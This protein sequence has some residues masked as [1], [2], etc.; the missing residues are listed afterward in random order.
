MAKT[1]L[2]IALLLA[3]AKAGGLLSRRLKMPEVL[4]ALL[5]GVI[6]GPAGFHL[7]RYDA[8]IQLLS[9]LGVVLLMFL[10]GIET[11]AEQFKKAGRSSFVI[12]LLGILVPLVAGTLCAF[13]FYRNLME[14]IF[15]GAILT[16]TSVS[17][18]VETLTELGRL[19]TRAGIHILGAAVIDDVLGLVL[20]SVLLAV[21]GGA[22]GGPLLLTVAGMVLF[23]LSGILAVVFLP[24]AARRMTRKIRPGGTLLTLSLAAALFAA[25]LAESLGI[26]AVTGAYLCGLVLSQSGHREYLE[27]NVRVISSGFLSPIFFASVGLEAGLDGLGSR[28][29]WITAV[30][31]LV[32]VAGKMVGCGA[33]ARLF[34]MSRSE[35]LQIGVGMI[36]RGE[37]AIIT[38]NLGLRNRIITQEIFLPTIL[39]VLLTT[40]VTPILLKLSFSR[41]SGGRIEAG[42]SAPRYRKRNDQK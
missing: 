16:A 7:V 17:I 29:V 30:M 1:L 33:A 27:R 32:A 20:I 18:T 19:N 24:R 6:L 2:S 35:S 37:V 38:A 39:V 10:A 31:F 22:T 8:G 42:S 26:A 21:N 34:R 12:A 11:D 23:C 25:F 3:A 4:G 5:A 41:R 15:V 9:N 40:L 13:F 28:T 14:N 36:S